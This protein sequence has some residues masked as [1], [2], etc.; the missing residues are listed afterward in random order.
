VELADVYPTLLGLLDITITPGV[1]GLDWSAA[2]RSGARIGREDIYSDMYDVTPQRFGK[3]GGPYMAV[4]TLRTDRWKLNIYPT[5]GQQYGQLFNLGEDP[6]E[7]RNLYG[8]NQYRDMREEMLW[9][10]AHRCHVN[11]DPMP[12][13][14]TQY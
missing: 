8:E 3:L 1:Q 7:T 6:D 5:A 13:Y 14:L 10:L 11:T 9:R 4:Q 2:L 12:P